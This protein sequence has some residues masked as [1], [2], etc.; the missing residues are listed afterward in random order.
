MIFFAWYTYAPN[1]QSSDASGQ[2]WYTGQA[3]YS[4]G[5]RTFTMPI[6]QTTG[7]IFDTATPSGQATIQVGTASV[8]KTMPS[9]HPISA[10]VRRWRPMRSITT[11]NW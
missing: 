5:A 7:G 2:R 11:V 1:G 6:Y 10:W 3:T 8:T 9:N 4:V